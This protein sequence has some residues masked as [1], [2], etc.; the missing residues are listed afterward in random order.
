MKLRDL[1]NESSLS[2]I[3]QHVENPTST[4]G[5]LS[6]SRKDL[7]NTENT[8]NHL[9]LKKKIKG[10]GLGFIELRGG[11]KEETGFNE[12]MSLFV[13]KINKKELVSLGAEYN[14]YSVLYK[15]KNIFVE[16]GTNK[17]SGVGTILGKFIKSSGKSNYDFSKEI[18]KDFFS[19][20]LKG[21][22]RGK[23]FLFRLQEREIP[24]FNRMAYH[25]NKPLQWITIYN[26]IVEE[27]K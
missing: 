23:K 3:W 21:S 1:I 15:D 20:L 11:Y 8:K 5:V 2:R 13:P 16:I 12:E 26:E 7:P 18:L 19:S 10:L 25:R 14:Q 6:A 17:N 22:H 9:E 27:N 4:F 24:S